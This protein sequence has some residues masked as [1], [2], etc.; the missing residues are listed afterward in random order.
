SGHLIFPP[1]GKVAGDWGVTAERN[2]IRFFFF[3]CWFDSSDFFPQRLGVQTKLRAVG[4][5]VSKRLSLSFSEGKGTG[6]SRFPAIS[7]SLS[8]LIGRHL[9]VRRILG[10]KFRGNEPVAIPPRLP[11]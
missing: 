10:P 11:V 4:W 9:E 2:V 1:I 5:L 7:L 8:P 6:C 3:V